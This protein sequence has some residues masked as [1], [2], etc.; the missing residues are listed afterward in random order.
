MCIRDRCD[1]P[2]CR[3]RLHRHPQPFRPGR[4]AASAGAAQDLS[5][6]HIYEIERI[7][8]YLIT[9]KNLNTYIKFNPTLLGYEF[10]RSTL[11]G[12]GYDY[13]VFDDHHFKACLLYTSCAD[14]AA[15]YSSFYGVEIDPALLTK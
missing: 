10:S 8:T 11:D 6:I 4:A 14:A 1:W 5:L 2:R 12:M 7:A 9:V 3:A 13:I 15:F